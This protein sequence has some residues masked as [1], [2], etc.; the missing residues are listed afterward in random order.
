VALPRAGARDPGTWPVG[1]GP[2]PA[3]RRQAFTSTQALD[4][5]RSRLRSPRRGLSQTRSPIQRRRRPPIARRG[6]R[7]HAVATMPP[8]DRLALIISRTWSFVSVVPTGS[9]PLSPL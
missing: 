4:R 9:E 2:P 8:A 5:R 1:D 6:R 7:R 3:H